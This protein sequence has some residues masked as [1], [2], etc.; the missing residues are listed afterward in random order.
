MSI[1]V[2]YEIPK[3]TF[4]GTFFLGEIFLDGRGAAGVF[5]GKVLK[6]EELYVLLQAARRG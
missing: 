3:N 2:T 6:V 1:E 5:L 4:F